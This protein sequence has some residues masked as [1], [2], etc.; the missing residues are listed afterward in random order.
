M[1]GED[2]DLEAM[3]TH[4]LNPEGY[5]SFEAALDIIFVGDQLR[6]FL[7]V[8]E[9]HD[10]TDQTAIDSKCDDIYKTYLAK[11]CPKEISVINQNKKRLIVTAGDKKEW[12]KD[13]F[14]SVYHECEKVLL[15]YWKSKYKSSKHY[16]KWLVEKHD[17][18]KKGTLFILFYFLLFVL[19]S[20]YFAFRFSLTVRKEIIKIA[21]LK[22]LS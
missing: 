19:S 6:F 22:S 20:H 5:K 10:L 11:K 18:R 21:L 14:D 16:T 17:K 3:I 12:T 2:L 1:E 15:D 13:M 7:A 9:L 4:I 8:R